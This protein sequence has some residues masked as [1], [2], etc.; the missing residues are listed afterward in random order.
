[1]LLPI[2]IIILLSRT[3]NMPHCKSLNEALSRMSRIIS[4]YKV[5]RVVRTI[6]YDIT[7]I[8]NTKNIINTCTCCYNTAYIKYPVASYDDVL[9]V[10]RTT[11]S[12]AIA[13]SW[14]TLSLAFDPFSRNYILKMYLTHDSGDDMHDFY[15]F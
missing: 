3:Y 11:R 9:F 2:D 4:C 15:V 7:K 10:L 1:M 14:K 8:L 5:I 6:W 12:T 13:T